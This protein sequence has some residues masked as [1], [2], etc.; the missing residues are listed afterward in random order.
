MKYTF[1]LEI[2]G[3]FTLFTQS[4]LSDGTIRLNNLDSKR[5]IVIDS[6][7][8]L[9]SSEKLYVEILAAAPGKI[10]APIS[11][12]GTNETRMPL[13]SG[14]YFDGGIGIIPFAKENGPVTF[15]IRIWRGL[16]TFERAFNAG[17]MTAVS[18]S[19]CQNVGSWDSKSTSLPTGAN[20][21]IP[22]AFQFYGNY[23]PMPPLSTFLI[24][25]DGTPS[26]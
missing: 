18:E 5:L 9:K 13:N 20:L 17:L 11:R 6:Q 24:K 12:L 4:C 25:E 16:P 7:Y 2:I 19:W 1:L 14:G 8:M 23:G 3:I 26:N 15:Q 21:E 10:L 22:I